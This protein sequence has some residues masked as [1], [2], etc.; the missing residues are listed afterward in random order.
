[1]RSQDGHTVT[2][3]TLGPKQLRQ[4]FPL[5]AHREVPRP[6]LVVERYA[7]LDETRERI[8]DVLAAVES[9]PAWDPTISFIEAH[10]SLRQGN[11]FAMREGGFLIRARV[12]DAERPRLI[13]W[14][15]AAPGGVVEV[16][17]FRMVTVDAHHTLVV[18]RAEF[19]KWFLRLAAWASDFGIGKQL[20]RTLEALRKTA[21]SGWH[22]NHPS[23]NHAPEVQLR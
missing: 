17:S 20:E 2:Y 22:W 13:R 15:G 11:V 1:M 14:R 18:E 12:L 10:G 3:S 23:L 6:D 16:H 5:S 8:Y 9:W 21:Q 4:V 19:K 7:V